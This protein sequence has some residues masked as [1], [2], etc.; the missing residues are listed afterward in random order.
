[1]N[2]L[3]NVAAGR[4]KADLVLKNCK[5][6]DVF[7]KN[8]ILGDIA[9]S[10]EYIAG[11]GNYSSDNEYDLAF[12]YVMPGFI[13]SHVHIE[14]SMVTP[15]EYAKAVMPNGVTTIIADPHEIANVC[16]ENGIN[17]MM[18]CAKGVPLTVEFMIPSCVPA[19]PFEHSGGCIDSETIK[20]LMTDNFLGL[21]EMMNYPGV[22][23]ADDEVLA[24]LKCADI[25]DGHAPLVTGNELNA[26]VCAGIKTDHECTTQSEMSEKISKG[27]YIQIREGTLSKNLEELV[28]GINQATVKRCTFCSDDRYLG[29][30]IKYGTIN[31]C[32]SKAISLGVEPLD[33]ITIATINAAECYGLKKVGAIAPGY[34]ADFVITDDLSINKIN[35]V[36]K[37]GILVAQ[38]KRALFEP[39]I[40]ELNNKVIRTVHLPKITGESFKIATNKNEIPVIRVNK[41]TIITTKVMRKFSDKL[42]KVAVI[43]RHKMIGNIGLGFVENYDI[44]GGAIASTI[45][46]DS[47]NVIV[48]GDNDE[49]MA[50]AVNALGENGGIAV[51]SKGEILERLELP[52]A[53][54]LSD[55]PIS[56]VLKS[57]ERLHSAAKMLSIN[58]EINPFMTLAFLT[59]PVIPEIRITD[60]G[61]FDV[62]KFEFMRL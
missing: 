44:M 53:G 40:T 21:G 48:I 8:V 1:M 20:N 55:K 36:Y 10:G 60:M 23:N 43:E 31:Y 7:S 22:I 50:F 57:H 6:V 32:I 3:I 35:R 5:I 13:D 59:L 30:I 46:H 2:R 25:I 11:I 58:P 28:G 42:S 34:F 52:I 18:Q 51:C 29:D 61:L 62:T 9:I 39:K 24:K 27:M 45:G 54:L 41:G 17:F 47:H 26:Y 16:G 38:D 15:I 14:S 4:E 49:D 56:E 12:K 37:K 19:T 33:A